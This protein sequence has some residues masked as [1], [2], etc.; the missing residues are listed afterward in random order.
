MSKTSR[1]TFEDWV[2]AAKEYAEAHLDLWPF[3]VNAMA[4]DFAWRMEGCP[5]DEESLQHAYDDWVSGNNPYSIHTIMLDGYDRM[6]QWDHDTKISCREITEIG[7]REGMEPWQAARMAEDIR[8]QHGHSVGIYKGEKHY[9]KWMSEWING[10]NRYSPHWV[11]LDE[12]NLEER[13]ERLKEL[14]RRT[15]GKDSFTVMLDTYMVDL[16]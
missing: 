12:V 10:N 1:H 16:S 5:I 13:K 2:E 14:E 15:A 3:Q 6:G 4:S 8:K 9:R 11:G 7:I